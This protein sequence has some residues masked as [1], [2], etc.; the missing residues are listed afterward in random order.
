V[1]QDEGNKRK[2]KPK[3]KDTKWFLN[4]NPAKKQKVNKE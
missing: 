3:K 1:E 2:F 4:G